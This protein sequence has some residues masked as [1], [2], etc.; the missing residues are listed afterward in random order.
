M[1]YLANKKINMPYKRGDKITALNLASINGKQFDIKNMQ[2]KRYMLSFFRF[3]ACPFCQLR[4]HQLISRWQELDDNFT[5][6]AIFDSPLQNLK[7]HSK[8]YAAP[9]YILADEEGKY[10]REF[11]IK[12]SLLKA[13]KSMFLKMPTLLYAMMIKGYFPSSLQGK[14]S[15]LPADFL[16]DENGIIQTAYYAKDSADH[17]SFEQVKI[18][19]NLNEKPIKLIHGKE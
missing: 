9:F 2:G 13:V 19:A 1:N 14:I 7:Q 12:Y 15:T 17:L 4:I 10:Y 3:S 11:A 8:R 6:I 5:I 18:F 16:V